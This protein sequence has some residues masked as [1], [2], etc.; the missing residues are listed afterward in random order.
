MED[1]VTLATNYSN[2]RL[3]SPSENCMGDEKLENRS[4]PLS[5]FGVQEMA[6]PAPWTFPC[7]LELF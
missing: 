5:A 2:R 6:D 7:F 3:H 1:V 4:G